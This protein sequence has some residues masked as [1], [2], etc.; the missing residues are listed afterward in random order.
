MG[1]KLAFAVLHLGSNGMEVVAERKGKRRKV[2]ITW[3]RKDTSDAPPADWPKMVSGELDF[4]DSDR[5]PP[6]ML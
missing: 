1:D 3:Q 4:Q 2:L 5:T 6:G